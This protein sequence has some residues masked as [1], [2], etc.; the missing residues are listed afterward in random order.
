MTKFH[1]VLIH[2]NTV[3][4]ALLLISNVFVPLSPLGVFFAACSL[5]LGVWAVFT[6]LME[7]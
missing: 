6:H 1:Y 3:C 7:P 5:G 4:S 2:L